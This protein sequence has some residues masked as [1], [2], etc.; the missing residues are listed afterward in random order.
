MFHLQDM[1]HG[2]S[3]RSIPINSIIIILLMI[4]LVF[5]GQANAAAYDTS[6]M[7]QFPDFSQRDPALNLP[8]GGKYYCVPVA[9]AN[10]LVWYA[11]ERGFSNLLPVTGLSITEK[12]AAVA[13]KLGEDQYMSTAP[14]GGTNPL[15]FLRG[16]SAYIKDAGYSSSVLYRGLWPMPRKYGKVEV[17]APDIDWIQEKFS[18][19]SAMFISLGFY[20]KGDRAGDLNRVGGHQVTVVGFGVDKSGHVDRDY[21]VLHDPDDG[22]RN[23]A[24]RYLKLEPLR[25]R[26]FVDSKGNE[27]DATD[28]LAVTDGMRLRSGYIA[29]VEA[30][31]ALDL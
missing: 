18:S 29:V 21:V 13:R 4:I 3:V 16:L 17:G 26:T 27:M 9:T 11:Q 12:V 14:K 2:A 20:K 30:V 15:Q 10:A 19:G 31:Y 7:D 6:R 23:V 24:R 5:G 25:N 1:H 22:S 8:G 28:F